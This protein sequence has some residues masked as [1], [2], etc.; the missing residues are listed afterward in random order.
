MTFSTLAAVLASSFKVLSAGA[1]A[2]GAK[3]LIFSVSNQIQSE[4]GP[5][6]PL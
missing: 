2:I 1:E 3:F 5:R 4:P 6:V